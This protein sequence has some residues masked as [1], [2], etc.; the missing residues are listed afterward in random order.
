MSVDVVWYL[1][2]HFEREMEHSKFADADPYM[3]VTRGWKKSRDL[4]NDRS[5]CFRGFLLDSLLP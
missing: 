2:S 1:C 4:T 5:S 3:F